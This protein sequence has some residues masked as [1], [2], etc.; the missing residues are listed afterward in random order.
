MIRSEPRRQT[1]TTFCFV[2]N[3]S[4][5][6]SLTE[7]NVATFSSFKS[8]FYLESPSNKQTAKI[9]K[10]KSCI[11]SIHKHYKNKTFIHL[12]CESQCI[13][14]EK[15]VHSLQR[16]VWM[17]S[18]RTSQATTAQDLTVIGTF[19]KDR[20]SLCWHSL[21]DFYLAQI[22]R[23]KVNMTTAKLFYKTKKIK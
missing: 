5:V 23:M 7:L 11:F 22:N 4:N 8:P 13:C 18:L 1:L 6:S 2:I 21:T 17:E 14:A 12:Q 3:I 9:K 16:A 15:D 10:N 19:K 20:S